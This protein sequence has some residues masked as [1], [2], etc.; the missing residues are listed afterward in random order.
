M[1]SK[2]MLARFPGMFQEHPKSSN[3][4][5][6]TFGKMRPI[7]ML[8]RLESDNQTIETWRT[9]HAEIGEVV[10]WDLTETPID[11]AR[12][13]C[14][15]EAQEMRCDYVLMIDADMAP[16][17]P[18]RGAKPFWDTAW[19]WIRQQRVPVVVAAP[20][21][22]PGHHQNIYV[23]RWANWQ[24]PEHE[25]SPSPRLVQYSR[26]E[27]SERGGFEQVAALPTGLILYDLEIFKKMAPPFFYY[28]MDPAHTR[29]LSTEDVTNTRDLTVLWSTTPGAG[30]YVAWDTW[31]RHVK[32]TEFG[33]PV[34]P[35]TATVGEFLRNSLARGMGPDDRVV[36]IAPAPESVEESRERLARVKGR[37]QAATASTTQPVDL[38]GGVSLTYQDFDE[39]VKRARGCFKDIVE[40]AHAG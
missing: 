40:S 16:D 15:I 22:G 17:E 18:R 1:K 5:R 7:E 37:M 13:R 20:Y 10:L 34:P 30:C 24:N 29:K 31:A 25:P 27:A 9:A 21:V 3:W 39:S 38:N 12:N 8:D 14:I 19:T 11:M 28:E 6:Q 32:L 23:F 33:G 26:E 35:S 36:D 2:V 4:V